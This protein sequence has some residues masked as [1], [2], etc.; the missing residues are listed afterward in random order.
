MISQ[1][2]IPQAVLR[3]LAAYN[4]RRARTNERVPPPEELM[5]WLEVRH[6]PLADAEFSA[7]VA[8]DTARR[9]REEE[10][11]RRAAAVLAHLDRAA[12]RSVET[13]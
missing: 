1:T 3:A 7:R 5:R 6:G 12:Y 11:E 4:D 2:V 10:R 8:Y 9:A 13:G